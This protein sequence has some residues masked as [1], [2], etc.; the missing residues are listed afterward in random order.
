MKKALVLFV[1]AGG[2]SLDELPSILQ[3][4]EE[5]GADIIEVGFRLA[6]LSP[7]AQPSR[8]VRSDH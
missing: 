3:A 2:P 5:G 7:T 4:L 6:I 1:T 8:Q